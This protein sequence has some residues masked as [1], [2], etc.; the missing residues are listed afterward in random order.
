MN[1]APPIVLY[2]G[3][4]MINGVEIVALATIDSGNVKTGKLI[5]TWILPVIGPLEASA[6]KTDDSV[7]G[8]C[9]RRRSMGGDCY[10]RL[11]TAPHM[12][13]SKWIRFGS[14]M[15]N[16]D[17]RTLEL[18]A[19]AKDY[20]LRLGAYGDPAAVPAHVWFDLISAIQP[21]KITGYSHQWRSEYAKDL[22]SIVMASCDNVA[23]AIEANKMG[24]RYFAALSDLND[25][26]DLPGS[27]VECLANSKNIQCKDCGICNGAR[28]GRDIQPASV[29]I[30]EHGP[31]SLRKAKIKRSASLAVLA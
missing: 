23:D 11:D 30:A 16:W 26:K 9:P 24:W 8:L 15:V 28:A 27:S 6:T 25:V 18:Q 10:A 1:I 31:M 17:E 21:S 2:V 19:Y 3:P 22:R 5:Q 20:G 12:A 13:W 14:P 29:W 7:C 4:S